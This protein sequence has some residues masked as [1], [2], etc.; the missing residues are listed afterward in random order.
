[1]Q[2]K[3]AALL[4]GVAA[5]FLTFTAA[6]GGCVIQTPAPATDTHV[7]YPVVAASDIR[8]FAGTVDN[9]LATGTAYVDLQ[10]SDSNTRCRGEGHLVQRPA[11]TCVGGAGRVQPALRRRRQ[12]RMPLS[13][14][15]V[16]QRLWPGDGP[17]R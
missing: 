5:C 13:T 2:F 6:L 15:L 14:G 1:M 3:S 9:N 7:Q 11:S 10:A 4:R 8:S 12:Y 16:R 17:G